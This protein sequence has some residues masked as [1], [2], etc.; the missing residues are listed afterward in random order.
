MTAM[1]IPPPGWV[2]FGASEL[3]GSPRSRLTRAL[4]VSALG[5]L[6]LL[7]LLL[8]V[9]A[10][11]PDEGVRVYGT[12]VVLVPIPPV[13]M[14]LL[15]PSHLSPPSG[16]PRDVGRVPSTPG[17]PTTIR[18][19]IVLPSVTGRP[20]DGREPAQASSETGHAAVVTDVP[21]SLS[22]EPGENESVPHEEEPVPI[23]HPDP[24]YPG[25]AREAGVQGTVQLHVLVGADGLVKRIVIRKDVIGLGEAA[26]VG[27]A[28]WTFRPARSH[29]HPVAVWILVPVHFS[30]P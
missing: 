26:E 21:P 9:E 16:F 15:P 14:P 10:R 19:D 23:F 27:I 7:A 12:P 25:W 28:R 11:H 6:T 22:R 30:L 20:V 24:D 17:D 1:T 8:W 3:R 29:G 18:G 13:A 4:V 5:H 2:P